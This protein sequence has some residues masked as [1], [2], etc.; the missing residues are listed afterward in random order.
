MAV[1]DPVD[2]DPL[3]PLAPLHAPDAE[4]AVAL[5]LDQVSVEAL[6]EFTVLGL[7]WSVITGGAFVTVTVADCMAEPPAPVHVSSYSVVLVSVPVD[8]VPVSATGPCHPPDAVHAEAPRAF[9]VRVALPPS[10]I[11]VCDA[12][13]VTTG[14]GGVLTATSTDWLAVPPVPVHASA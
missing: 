10:A 8:Q 7:A 14:A 6:P 13:R 3:I 5:L 12:A 9:Q 2:R 4:H 1:I 11:V